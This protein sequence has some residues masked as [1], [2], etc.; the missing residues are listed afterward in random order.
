[1]NLLSYITV[2]DLKYI[3]VGVIAVAVVAYI[4]MEIEDYFNND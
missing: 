3:V 1:M 2:S 4:W